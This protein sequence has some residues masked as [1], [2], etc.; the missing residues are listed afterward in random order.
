MASISA[1]LDRL[2]ITSLHRRAVAALAFA[3]FFELADLNTI[4]F[5]APG[6]IQQWHISVSVVALAISTSFA[7][8]F[9][10]AAGGGWFADRI[11][12]KR[13]LIIAILVYTLASL[14]NGLSW[15]VTTLAL[16][17]FVTGIGLSAMTVIANTYV[18]EVFPAHER[19]KYLGLVMTVGLIGIPATAW[20]ARFVVPF[21]PWGWRLVFVWGALGVFALIFATRIVESPRWLHLYGR[22]AEAETEVGMLEAAAL[23]EMGSLAEPEAHKDEQQ[24]VHVSYSELFAPAQCGRTFMLIIVWIFQTLGFYGFVTWVPTLLVQHGF[25][26][27]QSLTFASIMAIC[28]PLGAFIASRLLERVERKWFITAISLAIAVF[29]LLYGLTFQ[30]VLIVMFGALVVL[31]IQA[32]AVSAY[33]YTPELYPTRM[34]ASG[35]G[36]TYGAGRLA[37]VV[38][39]FIVSTLFVSYGYGSVFAYVA[40]CWLI[41]AIAVG[42]FGPRTTGRSLEALN[43]V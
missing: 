39:P 42:L 9:L 28:N 32:F 7:G 36:L 30:P 3:Y 20:V 1:R 18:G 10:G 5:A 41:V 4:G 14:A 13:G 22:N 19:G 35:H 15:D 23:A 16:F 33:V 21:A 25:T 8:M 43:Q 38:G 26:I 2:P 29:G 6:I 31:G 17:R 11:G 27:V 40:A 12:R 24:A 34:R 37:N